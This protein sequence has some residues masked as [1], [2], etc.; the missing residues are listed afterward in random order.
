MKKTNSTAQPIPASVAIPAEPSLPSCSG[1][2]YALPEPPMPPIAN[3]IKP[4]YETTEF[5]VTLAATIIPNVITL[6]S[7]FNVVPSAVASQMSTSVMA[8]VGGIISLVAAINYL[9]SR[10]EVKMRFIEME[11]NVRRYSADE[12]PTMLKM[13]NYMYKSKAINEGNF[14]KMSR[15]V[16]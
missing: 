13:L 9:N 4:G 11:E 5:W 14:L 8:I 3:V 15:M 6:L 16:K 2:I 1:E 7:I 12:K 10:T